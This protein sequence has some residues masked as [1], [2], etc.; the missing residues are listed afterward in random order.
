M[1]MMKWLSL[2]VS[3][4][5]IA[6]R[7]LEDIYTY[8]YMVVTSRPNALH[9]A[10][11]NKFG[12][13]VE[14]T[15]LSQAGVSDYINRYFTSQAKLVGEKVSAVFKAPSQ[16]LT[17]NELLAPFIKA[18]DLLTL[19]TLKAILEESLTD[20]P[21]EISALN[22][23]EAGLLKAFTQEDMLRLTDLYYEQ[24]KNA[25]KDLCKHNDAL[26]AILS[27]PINA[28]MAC[29][30]STDPDFSR[31]FSGDFNIGQLYEA[32]IVWL[33]KRYVSKF[34][35]K[36]A[37]QFVAGRVFA[38]DEVKTL[39]HIA[40]E[41]LKDGQLS[42]RG[43]KIDTFTVHK[44]LTLSDVIKYGLLKVENTNGN[45]NPLK[46]DHAFIH[47]SFQE[48]MT[49]H[50]LKEQLLSENEGILRE[51]TQF[52]AEHR[53][54]PKYQMTLKLLAGLVSAEQGV[55]TLSTPPPVVT[56]F[57]NA[58]TCNVD[59]F[60]ELG[61]ESKI[62][63]LMHLLAQS[64]RDGQIDSRNP[65]FLPLTAL[66]DEVVLRD[67]TSWGEPIIQ[68][69]YLS[70]PIVD[71]L[72]GILSG[73][74]TEMSTVADSKAEV[75]EES[76]QTKE[77]QEINI[78]HLKVA[79]EIIVNFV[80]R[81]E[82]GG[83]ESVSHDLLYIVKHTNYWQMR[84]LGLKKL[85][86]IIDQNIPEAFLEDCL[87]TSIPLLKEGSAANDACN[88]LV[89]IIKTV[90]SLS[91]SIPPL[92]VPL[93]KDSEKNVR[94]TAAQSLGEVMKVAP[95]IASQ[96]F[97]LL[98]PLLKDSDYN[99]KE[100]AVQSLGEVIK[101]DHT[102]AHRALSLLEPL[103]KDSEKNVR[104][105]AA[106]SLGEVVK[107]APEIALELLPLL[108]PLL[109]DSKKFIRETA[110]ESLGE[111]VKAAPGFALQVLDFLKS[112]DDRNVP[113]NLG[114]LAHVNIGENL[115]KMVMTAPALAS[116][117]LP[118]LISLLGHDQTAVREA[119]AQNLR[120]IVKVAPEMASQASSLLEPL[121][122]GSN[123]V[124][125]FFTAE[126]LGKVV[127]AI[128]AAA[129]EIFS[130]LTHLLPVSKV[131][132]GDSARAAAVQSLGEVVK[133]AP[134]MALEL[135]PLLKP[136]LKDSE[137][138]V[139]KA[140]IKS[141]GE[142]VKVAPEMAF[143]LLP[144]L[145]PLLQ[146]SS[147]EVREV[148]AESLREVVKAVVSQ[149]VSF[150][151]LF[152]QDSKEFV[153]ETAVKSLGEVVKM[154]PEMAL[155]L[156]PLLKPLLKD[157]EENVRKA[158]VQSLGEVVKVAPEMAFELLPLL[159][160]LLK[161]S[162]ENVKKTVLRSLEE[163]V[164]ADSALASQTLP[165]VELLLKDSDYN[166][167]GAAAESLGEVVE[168]A[169]TVAPH[170][171]SLLTLLLKDSDGYIKR[172]VARSLEEVTKALPTLAPQVFSLLESLLEDYHWYV[173]RAVAKRLGEVVKA[174]HALAHRAVSLLEPLLKD[175]NGY[176]REAAVESL[177]KI[178]I[179]SPALKQDILALLDS[180]QYTFKEA[181]REIFGGLPLITLATFLGQKWRKEETS[182]A[183]ESAILA[184][185]K[186]ANTE[187]LSHEEILPLFTVI[188]LTKGLDDSKELNF[189]AKKVLKQLASTLD[190][191]GVDWIN[192]YFKQLPTLPERQSFLKDVYHTLLKR[193]YIG[194]IGRDFIINCIQSGLTTTI[195]RS[196]NIILEGVAYMLS[197]DSKR[198]LSAI[199][200]AALSQ[201]N[202][203]L[204]EQ[205]REYL[206]LFPNNK[207][208]LRVAAN[209]IG[210]VL[211]LVEPE[212]GGSDSLS[213]GCWRLTL[214][215]SDTFSS[216]FVLLEKRNRFGDRVAQKFNTQGQA[217]TPKHVCHPE[218]TTRAFRES[219][220]GARNLSTYEAQSM[221]LSED[222]KRELFF[223]G[224]LSDT[225]FI[226]SQSKTFETWNDFK[227]RLF[228][229]TAKRY[230]RTQGDLLG[231]N[232][233][234]E[235]GQFMQHEKALQDGG[236]YDQAVLKR[237]F[238]DF[239]RLSP[240]L[241]SYCKT[242]YWTM[243]NY[244]EA[245]R[246]L[247]TSLVQG[248][249]SAEITTGEYMATQGVTHLATAL[250]SVPIVGSAMGILDTLVNEISGVVVNKRFENKVN[251]LTIIISKKFQ[252]LG[253]I[254][255]TIAKVALAVT[256]KRE[257][258]IRNPAPEV[259][260]SSM[261]GKMGRIKNGFEEKLTNLKNAI[262]STIELSDPESPA[263]QL[264]LNDVALTLA[265]LFKNHE[266]IIRNKN[267]LD[268]QM[269]E[270]ISNGGL[271][272]PLSAPPSPETNSTS[273]A[274][275]NNSKKG[276][277]LQ[278]KDKKDCVIM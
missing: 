143:E 71:N 224:L 88:L 114:K 59:G 162:E 70:E 12:R 212:S 156:V 131:P 23:T 184:K 198:H 209:D 214:L 75:N 43:E 199:T 82:F 260:D 39:G 112:L 223:E 101:A 2:A 28:A 211:S 85:E 274:A 109:Q 163:V 239:E 130:L 64:K 30:V 252:T 100:T 233:T 266:K 68:S 138:N 190:D 276:G 105:A 45:E 158:A 83:R 4:D 31:T 134:E 267:S 220:F 54:E 58:V 172:A 188:D 243:T 99:G 86:Q 13:K 81:S 15:G 234:S 40:Y 264:A 248:N 78:Q 76:T 197:P 93:L 202:D 176:I 73:A 251:A 261:M 19:D 167:K 255:S 115:G 171:L 215:T 216:P 249:N 256:H 201:Q 230:S 152:L 135:V 157:S 55:A 77:D 57:W 181:A 108:K 47:L 92:L 35:G 141:L 36:D 63:L 41:A 245:Y 178:A 240:L 225:P 133:V 227:T 111:V 126:S 16:A 259:I 61:L 166:F 200:Q 183:L 84:K 56:R 265:Y 123:E 222:K 173:K 132:V 90:P 65:H 242:F 277:T 206:P 128:P 69:T 6:S 96:A 180:S 32:V 195:T 9:T 238:E 50:L 91:S 122:K 129:P 110:A 140:A 120:E 218:E 66:I 187:I 42:M 142:I 136:L 17:Q 203:K 150:L 273:V 74:I 208:G 25:L 94:K 182:R 151:K 232:P 155:E 53:N 217:L 247:S 161:D 207:V 106:Q 46:Q 121:L 253:D 98:E 196:G 80:N 160:P 170:V 27:V 271:E 204:A 275:N 79:M 26:R 119:A 205:Y 246:S 147:P 103:L 18:K 186:S 272:N 250:Q 20:V 169:P 89:K 270:I 257:Q 38:M 213:G 137:K 244:F 210:G 60:L 44:D 175:S 269:I 72:K 193:G 11:V 189:A 116:Q 139:R 177:R 3:I 219:L 168:A 37:S 194:E 52:I 113:G 228:T 102:L 144:L 258:A 1:D 146:Q 24:G 192:A 179:T 278:P 29:L 118:Q 33:G 22:L 229:Q 236:V 62:T 107:V 10:L 174:D 145:E 51:A 159:E 241:N 14:S 95:E 5:H 165:L 153:R 124:V 185:L 7:V 34:Q 254:N 97:L 48:Y 263:V 67:I 148:V 164:K 87:A 235:E 125:S 117:A 127:A 49:A 268:V 191:V 154:A 8:P 231:I 262:L 149:N 21:K 104:K 221:L 226:D 237:G